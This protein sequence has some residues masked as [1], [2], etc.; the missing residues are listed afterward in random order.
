M[1]TEAG[2]VAHVTQT[3]RFGPNVAPD[4]TAPVH[5]TP[6]RGDI[7]GLRAISVVAVIIYHLFPTRFPA[8]GLGVDIFFV[9]SGYLIGGIVLASVAARRFTFGDFYLR[10]LRRIV[11]AFVVM[12]IVTTIVSAI[13]LYPEEL[14]S[15]AKSALA[16]LACIG[17]VFFYFTSDY[18]AAD[19][20]TLPLLHTWSLGVEEQF[21]LVFPFLPL[22]IAHSKWKRLLL[23]IMIATALISL[24]VSATAVKTNP[25]AAFYL[26]PSRWW[27]LMVG[28]LASQVRGDWLKSRMLARMFGAAAGLGMIA[29]SL[30][31]VRPEHGFPGLVVLPACLGAAL[32]LV[33]GQGTSTMVH[34]ALSIFPA[35]YIGLASYSLYLWHWPV[36]VLYRQHRLIG[37]LSIYDAVIV[38]AVTAILGFASWKFV[39]GP[40]RGKMTPRRLGAW[41]GGLV[42]IASLLQIGILA[43]NGL[44]QRFS[45][46]VLSLARS[47]GQA[48]SMRKPKANCFL[49]NQSS[50]SD[51][52][53]TRCLSREPGK[54]DW[55]LV[56]DSHASMMWRGLTTVLPQVHFQT[57]VVFG[58]E[59]PLDPLPTGRVCDDL[60]H[61][62]LVRDL[63]TARPDAVVVTWRWIRLDIPA[64]KR[65]HDRLAGRGIPLI[66]MGPTPEYSMP[67]PRIM[68][69]SVRRNDPGLLA[70]TIEPRLWNNDRELAAQAKTIGYTYLSPLQ[71]MCPQRRC[72]VEGANGDLL[73]F[74]AGHYNQLGA[75]TAVR[76]LIAN[77]PSQG[78]PL[79]RALESTN[80]QTR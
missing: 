21:Y 44:P 79:R 76:R 50:V 8:G 57:A 15:L 29:A 63:D 35:R 47:G 64:L 20:A 16:A 51:F 43:T 36:I 18:F 73:Y 1:N 30:L 2:L 75:E 23:P 34:R 10:R 53:K 19:S 9:I 38:L 65:L 80:A 4:R 3:N 26:L 69:E 71:A 52:D 59:M 32:V 25:A 54:P 70:R 12:I 33:T 78:W 6:Y 5:V 62:V 60:M 77:D 13:P 39:E 27:E 58:C 24:A 67:V 74:D 22:L 37:K 45:P 17:N 56:G 42:A 41:C 48:G 68:A 31:L 61:Q 66:V 11:P 49:D 55:L 14:T 40:F 28:V 7:D 72:I 46:A